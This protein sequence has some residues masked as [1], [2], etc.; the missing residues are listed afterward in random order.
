MRPIRRKLVYL[1]YYLDVAAQRRGWSICAA[2]AQALWQNTIST[3][4]PYQY[5]IWRERWS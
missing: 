3:N 5:R 4:Y 2:I 1:I